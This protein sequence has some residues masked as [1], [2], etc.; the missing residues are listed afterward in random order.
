MGGRL[1]AVG[2]L[3]LDHLADRHGEAQTIDLGGRVTMR[4][5][6]HAVM[7]RIASA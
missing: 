7:R 5:A 1:Q 4:E 2:V 6:A 3:L